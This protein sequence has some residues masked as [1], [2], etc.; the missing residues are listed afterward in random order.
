MHKTLIRPVL[1]YYCEA[2]T[3]TES[4]EGRLVM[5]ERKILR[6]IFGPVCGNNL[7]CRSSIIEA[8]EHFDGPHTVKYIQFKRLQWAHHVVGMNDTKPKKV[9]DGKFHGGRPVG[10][11]G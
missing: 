2:R 5:F 11:H 7:G 4:S 9:L 1:S 8:Y 10:C 6:R 3:V